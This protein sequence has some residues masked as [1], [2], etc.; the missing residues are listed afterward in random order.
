M[1]AMKS[2]VVFSKYYHQKGAEKLSNYLEN[3]KGY[4]ALKI[5][6]TMKPEAITQMVKDSEL[7]G[8]GGAGFPAGTKWGF[9]PKTEKPKYTELELLEQEFERLIK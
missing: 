5:A 8:R 2:E 1:T 6:L 7:R 9:I 4:E 3:D